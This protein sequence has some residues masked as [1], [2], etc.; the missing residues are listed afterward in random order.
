MT[1]ER[2]IELQLLGILVLLATGA[3][4][5]ARRQLA[6]WRLVVAVPQRRH[7][8]RAHVEPRA[9]PG[10]GAA[11]ANPPTDLRMT[12]EE[13][14]RQDPEGRYRLPIGWS[15][16]GEEA[17]L[18]RARLVG[19]VNHILVSGQSDGGKDTWA[20]GA[21]LSLCAQHQPSELQLCVVDGKGLDFVGFAGKSHVW[22][23]AL[24]PGEIAPAMKAL[25][26]ER[27][28]RRQVLQVAGVSKW[29]AYRGNL[30]LLVVYISELSLL[31]DA[32]G[33]SDLESWLN[34]ELAAGRA[35]GIRYI[36]ATQTAS[37]YTTRWR[38]Q[39]G[40]YLAGFQPTDSQ[41]E[42]N[43]GLS[44]KQIRLAGTVPPSELPPPPQGA[45]VFAAVFGREAVNVRAPLIDDRQ[46]AAWLARLPG[47][48]AVPAELVL[49][50]ATDQPEGRAVGLQG[51][52]STGEVAAAAAVLADT[53]AEE[54]ES[55]KIRSLA[56]QGWSRNQIASGLGGNR[57][58]ALERIRRALADTPWA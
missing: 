15:L 26:A 17:R 19:D 12:L 39:I 30:P 11:L 10:A 50:G 34:S 23:L 25:T 32:V 40:L 51:T 6:L 57:Q 20:I 14:A 46:R 52:G 1:I 55:A 41:D 5:W 47:L 49:E 3:W 21:L 29:D 27:D 18:S 56:A 33:K 16:V 35:F 42:P 38:S 54:P 31:Q 13:L 7:P 48:P 53:G 44:T 36:I 24:A 45:G 43:T 9:L 28:R 37:N 22:R 8:Q 2:G 4:F 58:R